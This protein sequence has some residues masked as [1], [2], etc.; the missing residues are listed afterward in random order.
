MKRFQSLATVLTAVVLAASPLVAQ[1]TPGHDAHVGVPEHI[2]VDG[3]D[4]EWKPGPALL[5]PGAQF[6][7]LEGDPAKEGPFTIR[8]QMPA[9]YKVSPHTHEGVEHV[10][11]LSGR[12]GIGIGETWDGE[13]IR[14]AGP[15]GFFVM[16]SGVPH[17]A[18]IEEDSVVQVHALGPWVVKY[19]NPA[20]DPRNAPASSP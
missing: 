13:K 16:Q 5:P 8:L 4:I 15:G 7:L 9:G 11:I 20:D 3:D 17:Y 12:A 10:T 14:Y 19:V 6:A 2:A 18:M 1:Q